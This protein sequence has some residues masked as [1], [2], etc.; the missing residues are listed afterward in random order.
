M[1]VVPRHQLL[2]YSKYTFMHIHTELVQK[3]LRTSQPESLA[4]GQWKQVI[5]HQPRT[6]NEQQSELWMNIKSQMPAPLFFSKVL[7][8]YPVTYM[9]DH[10]FP[11]LFFLFKEKLYVVSIYLWNTLEITLLQTKTGIFKEA[12]W[13]EVTS[14]HHTS[15]KVFSYKLC[16]RVIRSLPL[17]YSTEL[18]KNLQKNKRNNGW[19]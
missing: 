17:I 6:Q 1:G 3:L 19:S 14:L 9:S 7:L 2:G 13:K 5:H 11:P 15:L 18:Y 16:T 12:S 10:V 4:A 8:K